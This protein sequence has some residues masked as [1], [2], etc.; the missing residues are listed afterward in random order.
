MRQPVPDVGPAV[1][2]KGVLSQRIDSSLQILND[3]DQLTQL[4]SLLVHL[5][6]N[7][8]VVKVNHIVISWMVLLLFELLWA[9]HRMEKVVFEI[10]PAHW[11]L[12]FLEKPLSY[13]FLMEH[14]TWCFN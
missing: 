14:V 2:Q 11:A 4:C 5:G 9:S 10:L 3:V 6:V 13:A 7:P 8:R 1:S 12:E